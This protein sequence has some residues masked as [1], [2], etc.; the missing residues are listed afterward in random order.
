MIGF[1]TSLIRLY[2]DEFPEEIDIR[3]EP[4]L[5]FWN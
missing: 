1:G 5:L 4:K 3:T 2:V